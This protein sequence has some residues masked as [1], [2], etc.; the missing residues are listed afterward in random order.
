VKVTC[1]I[2]ALEITNM[3]LPS[4]TIIVLMP[5]YYLEQV[6]PRDTSRPLQIPFDNDVDEPPA[7]KAAPAKKGPSPS[8]NP[9]TLG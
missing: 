6:V 3:P 8:P 9:V 5:D 1:Y 2:Y 4:H 7:K